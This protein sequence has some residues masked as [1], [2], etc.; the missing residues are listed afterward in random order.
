M[1]DFAEEIVKAGFCVGDS[2]V[3]HIQAR[4]PA[5]QV[6]QV[7]NGSISEITFD[8]V[9]VFDNAAQE[10][11]VFDTEINEETLLYT[12]GKGTDQKTIVCHHPKSS[13]L[14]TQAAEETMNVYLWVSAIEASSTRSN[15][16]VH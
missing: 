4:T 10:D 16:L 12:G 13:I 1:D 7:L 3:C 15:I 5:G 8:G 9:R 2:V 6:D 11:F 14:I